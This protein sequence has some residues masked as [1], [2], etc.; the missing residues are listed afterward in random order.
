MSRG[1]N[2]FN[3]QLVSYLLF[4]LIMVVLGKTSRKKKY[5]DL[6]FTS[7]TPF[8]SKV[9][10]LKTKENPENALAMMKKIASLGK[11]I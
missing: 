11:L 4:L 7:P 3:P 9:T 10:S 1:I 8:I 2:D 6:D 5:P